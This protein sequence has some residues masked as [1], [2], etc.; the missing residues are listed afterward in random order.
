VSALLTPTEKHRSASLCTVGQ[1]G[2]PFFLPLDHFLGGDMLDS[3]KL[4]LRKSGLVIRAALISS[5]AF[6][7]GCDRCVAWRGVAT[8]TKEDKGTT[9][10]DKPGERTDGNQL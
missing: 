6:L 1:T 4:K 5:L 3:L 8:D 2:S 7:A 9:S 10:P